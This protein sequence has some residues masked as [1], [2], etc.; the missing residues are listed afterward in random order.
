MKGLEKSEDARGLPPRAPMN[1]VNLRS[2]TSPRS[3]YNSLRRCNFALSVSQWAKA[4]KVW[5]REGV[6]RLSIR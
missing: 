1:G 5:E 3:G 2:Y 4:D 6:A